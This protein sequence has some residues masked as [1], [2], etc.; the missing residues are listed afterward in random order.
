MERLAER[1]VQPRVVRAPLE[2]SAQQRLGASEVA[3][4]KA[5]LGRRAI[6]E[7][8]V[9]RRARRVECLGGL[10][11]AQVRG[12]E[13]GGI[14]LELRNLDCMAHVAD[15]ELGLGGIATSFPEPIPEA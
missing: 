12:G 8:R 1:E 15:V 7:V 14:L 10:A 11:Q 5:K 13:D 9:A 2:R 3:A 4:A 6:L